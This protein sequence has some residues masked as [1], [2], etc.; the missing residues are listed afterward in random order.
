MEC[1]SFKHLFK[2]PIY[3]VMIFGCLIHWHQKASLIS[4]LSVVEKEPPF[5]NLEELV[6]SPYQVTTLADSYLAQIWE[7]GSSNTFQDVWNTKFV[8]EEKSLKKTEEEIVQQGLSGQ[9]A[10]YRV[11]RQKRYFSYPYQILPKML[12]EANFGRKVVSCA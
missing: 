9:Y 7:K 6:T 3:F 4:H 10:I 8:D 11:F 5:R 1:D 12:F 2:D